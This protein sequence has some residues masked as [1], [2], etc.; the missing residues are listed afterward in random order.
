[1]NK[2]EQYMQRRFNL[3][4][5]DLIARIDRLMSQNTRLARNYAKLEKEHKKLAIAYEK[6]RNEFEQTRAT[7]EIEQ[8]CD[9]WQ[10]IALSYANIV[11]RLRY[12]EH[13]TN[14]NQPNNQTPVL[15]PS[16]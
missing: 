11:K 3:L 15:T 12:G 7:N 9:Y 6:L 16:S 10:G 13:K 5:D 2:R 14:S 4:A 8:E 1:M